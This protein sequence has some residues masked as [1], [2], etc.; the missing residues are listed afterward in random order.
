MIRQRLIIAISILIGLIVNVPVLADAPPTTQQAGSEISAE[1]SATQA[2]GNEVAVAP[3]TTQPV[4]DAVMAARGK[5]KAIETR[6]DNEFENSPDFKTAVNR[7]NHV[8]AARDDAKSRVLAS[9]ATNR[10]YQ[11]AVQH[12]DAAKQAIDQARQSND[13]TPDQIVDLAQQ[14][15]TARDAVTKMEDDAMGTEVAVAEKQL[16]TAKETLRHLRQTHRDAVKDDPDW[17][18][19]EKQWEAA[20]AAATRAPLAP[21]PDVAEPMIPAPVALPSPIDRKIAEKVLQLG[22]KVT[23]LA[24]GNEAP[25]SA[26]PLPDGDFAVTGISLANIRSIGDTDV[27]MLHAATSLKHLNLWATKVSD[28]T[29]AT[30]I[31]PLLQLEDLNLAWTNITD[32]SAEVIGGMTRL[33]SL[34]IGG[35]QITDAG[36]IPIGKLIH[37]KSL[38]VVDRTMTDEGLKPLKGLR[39]LTYLDAN[40]TNV[41]G[42]WA[43]ASLTQLQHLDL[44]GSQLTDDGLRPILALTNLEWLDVGMGTKITDRGLLTI[45]GLSR[46]TYLCISGDEVTDR[47]VRFLSTLTNLQSMVVNDTLI[48]DATIREALPNCQ[49]LR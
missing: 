32:K 3:A 27:N 28:E 2:A 18:A 48:T 46:L 23:L 42:L 7:V 1:P 40:R 29:V 36:M 43:I 22:G 14:A 33:V 35:T 9:L 45:G 26:L 16:A 38:S 25:W 20:R 24:H 17:K 47:G 41:S 31:A 21:V 12:R 34:D 39:E 13:S 49:I 44:H 6:L 8:Q 5:L 11:A 4:G 37:L 19:A 30:E 15:M 10:D